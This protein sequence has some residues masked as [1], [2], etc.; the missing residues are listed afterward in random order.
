MAH[1][2]P[3]GHSRITPYL[4]YED[5]EA[6]LEFLVKAF[7]FTEQFRMQ[8]PDGSIGHAEL[9]LGDGH[10][11]LGCPGPDYQ[12]PKRQGRDSDVLVHIYV[13]D[14]DAHYEQA[15]AA[16]ATII[17]E[18]TDQIYGD[19]RYIALDP[20]GHRWMIAQY[21]RDVPNWWEQVESES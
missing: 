21:V 4:A 14:V 8:M 15:K 11:M 2:V 3:A 17:E 1:D 19:R 13:A 20:E 7:G 16:G 9:E 18:P 5:G 6:A 12:S 10:I